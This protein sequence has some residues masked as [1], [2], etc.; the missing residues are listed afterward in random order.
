[1]GLPETE[2]WKNT[3]GVWLSSLPKHWGL[4]K[5]R[6]LFSFGRGLGITKS[7]LQDEGIPCI[8]YGEIH[9][10]YGF[11]VIPEQHDLKCVAPTYL[12]TGLSSLLKKGDFVFADTSED[13]EGS[14]NFSHLN[15]DTATFAGYHTIIARLETDDLPRFMAYLFDSQVYRYQI[16][17]NVSGVKVF[18]ITQ[19]I[20]K[21]S[22]VWLPT[23]KEQIQIVRFLDYKMARI[24]RLIK[25]KKELVER[26]QE[27]RIAVI[28][29]AVTKGLNVDV[30]MKPTGVDWLGDVPEH[31]ATRRLKL[32]ASEPLKYGANEAAELDDRDLP[33]YIRITDVKEDGNLHDDTFRSIPE[34][35]AMPYLLEDGDILLARSGATVGKSFQYS[36]SWG[37]AAY[38]GYLIR[39]RTNHEL[40]NTKFAYLFLNSEAY[41]ANINSTLIQSTIQNFSAEKYANI[42]IPLPPV[43]E[44]KEIVKQVTK[45]IHHID[46]MHKAIFDAI[47]KLIEYRTAIITAAVTG[48]IDVRDVEIPEDSI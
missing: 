17:K 33:R 15:S 29:Q 41:W 35:I 13:I 24:D 25:K 18:S 43:D 16:R 47:A 38:A 39:F 23:K 36:D 20:L 44:Q 2:N 46:Q 3:E 8:N 22:Y 21:S 7:N 28:T 6:Y 32:L 11:E 27:Q 31:W 14:G 42:L 12:E 45:E 37:V 34:D 30:P 5:I 48:K 4:K 40:I 26:L 10:K 19:D 9:S 1:M